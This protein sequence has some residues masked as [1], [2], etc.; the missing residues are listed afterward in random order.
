MAYVSVCHLL[1]LPILDKVQELP[2]NL[3]DLPEGLKGETV[4]RVLFFKE[5]VA[6]EG[7]LLVGLVQLGI[8]K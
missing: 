2:L 1:K 5:A 6:A 4:I 7:L 3:L 8:D